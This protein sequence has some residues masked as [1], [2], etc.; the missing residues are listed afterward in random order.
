[1]RQ[2][3]VRS[4]ETSRGFVYGLGAGA[5]FGVA[6]PLAKR[7]V[8]DV[9]PLPLAGLLYLGGALG[10]G[11]LS[12]A[13]DPRATREAGLRRTDATLLAAMILVGGLV[14]P[15]LLLVGLRHASGVA[16]ALLL[17]LEAPFTMLLAV[18]AFGEHL[19][20]RATVGAAL[21]VSGAALLSFGPGA[22][23]ADAAGAIAIAGA[24]LAWAVDT[25]LATRLALRDPVAVARWKTTGAGVLGLALAALGG[26]GVPPPAAIVAALGVGFVGYGVSL[27][28]AVRAMRLLGAARQAACFAIGPFVGALA[29]VPFLGESLGAGEAAVAALMVA[30]L[31]LL[32]REDHGHVHTHEAIAHEHAHVHDAHHRHPHAGRVDE[33]HTH[34]HVHETVTHAHP[35]TS[36]A[37]HRHRH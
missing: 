17:N 8:V 11:V 7:L 2:G 36:D 13:R 16:G 1:M 18:A 27:V 12:L 21:V 37:H 31:V 4:G 20:A 25:N 33:P 15:V 9:P 29:A 32:W 28:L 14:G 19:G 10:L 3:R 34:P 24:C 26:Y 5:T 35:H 22:V 23:R 30:G 6:A